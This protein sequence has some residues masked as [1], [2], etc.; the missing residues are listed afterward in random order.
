MKFGIKSIIKKGIRQIIKNIA[1]GLFTH[2]EL[3]NS[4]SL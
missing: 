1:I 4:L 2:Y 3:A